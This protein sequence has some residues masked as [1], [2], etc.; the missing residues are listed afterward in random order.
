MSDPYYPPP[1]FY[2][3]LTVL[4]SATALSLLTDTD[5]AFQEISGIEAQ[6]QAEEVTEGG[7]NRFVHRLPKQSK[8]SNLVLKRGAVTGDSTLIEWAGLTVGS[9]LTLPILTQNL[10]VML[11]GE[12]SIPLIA[13][14]FVNAYPIKTQIA[15]LN[16]QDNKVLIESMEFSYNYFERLNL[17]GGLSA[18]VK[19]AS[20]VAR[21]AAGA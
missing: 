4:G 15:G 13:W 11:L 3:T 5:A 12:N 19:V 17:G 7:E 2:F 6:S 16:A 21:I 1:G 9:S 14:A 8:Y 20:L 18:A 10:L